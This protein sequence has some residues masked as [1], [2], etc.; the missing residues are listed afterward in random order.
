M[1]AC[2]DTCP[3]KARTFGDINDPNSEAAKLLKKHQVVRVVNNKSD[4]KPNMYYIDSTGPTDWPHVAQMPTP[5]KAMTSFMTPALQAV[6]GL[7][8]LGVLAMWGRQI[9][10]GPE[11]NEA[12]KETAEQSDES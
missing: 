1:P 6:V 7:S 2:V 12:H 3:T 9:I 10:S 4:T 5:M 11:D 8:G